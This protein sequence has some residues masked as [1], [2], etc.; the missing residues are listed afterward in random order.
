MEY[1]Q[2]AVQKDPEFAPAYAGIAAVWSGRRQMGIV[3]HKEAYIAAKK[4]IDKALALDSTDAEVLYDYAI[5]V[6]WINWD[7][8]KTEAA[9]E[10]A[11]KLNPNHANAHAYYSNF[12]MALKKT[13]KAMTHIEIALQLD[14]YNSVIEALYAINLAF[15]GRCDE[16]ISLVSKQEDK[17]PLSRNA[18]DLC[19]FL[20]GM[21][22]EALE[23]KI[24]LALKKKDEV[25]KN[26]L[27]EGYKEGGYLEVL[28]REAEL[29]E[30]RAQHHYIPVFHIAI[31]FAE[32][33]QK[34]KTLKLLERG[35]AEHDADMPYL[36]IIPVFD[37]LRDEPRFKAILRKMELPE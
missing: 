36:T 23:A 13:D 34:E 17:H 22:E 15:L 1:Y 11:L 10:K 14:P 8:E 28:R 7:W 2:L 37:F 30:E 16:V 4:A 12:L 24:A 25:L 32:S 21:Y 6:G 31:I 35:L 18:L 5:S 33:G 20:E 26:T 27:E 3:P 9:Y 29:L 19:Y